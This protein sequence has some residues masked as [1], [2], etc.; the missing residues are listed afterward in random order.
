VLAAKHSALA[1]HRGS[2]ADGADKRTALLG[3]VKCLVNGGASVKIERSGHT[4][5]QYNAVGRIVAKLRVG[6]VG[7]NGYTVRTLDIFSAHSDGGNFNFSAAHKVKRAK[8]L[9]F[10]KAVGK[11]KIYHFRFLIFRSLLF[12]RKSCANNLQNE[13]IYDISNKIS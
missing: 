13:K 7:A 1:K 2:G 6:Y 8:R 3:G 10:L 11:K 4:A 5:G 9:A 12:Y